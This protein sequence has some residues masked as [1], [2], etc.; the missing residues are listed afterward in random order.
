[1]VMC[2][3]PMVNV[4]MYSLKRFDPVFNFFFF[5]LEKKSK[6]E[7]CLLHIA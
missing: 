3:N 5:L 1:M 6:S 7:L 2:G 4:C